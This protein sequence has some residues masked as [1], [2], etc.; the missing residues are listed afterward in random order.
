VTGTEN[1]SQL[2]TE[3]ADVSNNVVSETLDELPIIGPAAAAATIR[4]VNNV[5]SLVT[6]VYYVPGSQVKINGAPSNSQSILH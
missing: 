5:L 1:A 6:G 2:K 4:N 3:S